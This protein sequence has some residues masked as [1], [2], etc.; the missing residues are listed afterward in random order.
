MSNWEDAS[1]GGVSPELYVDVDVDA[2][3]EVEF[4]EVEGIEVIQPP[5]PSEY[6]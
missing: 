5:K 3:P 2:A 4:V 6:W 1:L